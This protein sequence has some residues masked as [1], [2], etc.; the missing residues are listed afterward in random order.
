ML[1]KKC[2]NSKPDI[3][4]K[5]HNLTTKVDDGTHKSYD[6]D[7]EKEREDMFKRHDF[8]AFRCN[9][10]AP[11][12]ELFKLVGKINLYITKLREKSSK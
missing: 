9:L 7:D 11:Y 10:N 6:T 5:N 1:N 8:K 3:W 4:L 12:F 2:N